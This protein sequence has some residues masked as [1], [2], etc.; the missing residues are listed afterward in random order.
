MNVNPEYIT[1]AQ[2]IENCAMYVDGQC[3][4]IVDVVLPPLVGVGLWHV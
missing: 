2:V 1:G 4:G 3:V